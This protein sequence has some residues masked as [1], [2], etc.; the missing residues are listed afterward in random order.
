MQAGAIGR[1]AGAMADPLRVVTAIE[2]FERWSAPWTFF[3]TVHATPQLTA[4]DRLL[5]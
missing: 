3:D 4:E 2:S 1:Q 5:L